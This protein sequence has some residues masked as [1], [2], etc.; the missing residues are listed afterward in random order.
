MHLALVH[1]HVGGPAGGGGGVRQMLGLARGLI[2]LGH[3]VTVVCHDFE[4]GPEAEGLRVRA[5]RTG[6]VRPP[7]S[8]RAWLR[9]QWAGMP[10]VARLVPDDVD[11]VNAHEWPAVHAGRRAAR[12]LGVPLV[13]CRNDE[14]LAER[15]LRPGQAIAVRR[16]PDQRALDLLAGL[17]ALLAARRAEAVVVLDPRC[18]ETVRA[19]AGRQAVVVGSGPAGFFYDAPPRPVARE[20]LGIPPERRLVVAVGVMAPHRRFEDLL[21]A[22]RLMPG[23]HAEIVGSDHVAPRY[24]EDVRA[25]AARLGGRVAIRSGGVGEERLRDLYAAADVMVHPVR[26]QTWG[27]APLEALA[28]GTPVVVSAGAAVAGVLRGRPGVAVV[29]PGDPRAIAAAVEQVAGAGVAATRAWLRETFTDARYA[30]RIVQVC[31]QA[32]A[33]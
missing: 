29:E 16:R 9:R 22:L 2:E 31:E 18:A 23:T 14:T 12:R 19:T 5:V 17:P 7:R 26:R 10:A 28:A 1:D 33:R 4:P 3:G 8:R 21:D 27:L 11:V 32:G 24:A 6:R 25:R 13:W 20:R 15:A 30:S